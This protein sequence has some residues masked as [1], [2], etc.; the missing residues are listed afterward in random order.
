MIDS[1]PAYL[2][3]PAGTSIAGD[4]GTVF[5]VLRVNGSRQLLS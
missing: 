1:K 4:D 2:Y 3:L 5:Y